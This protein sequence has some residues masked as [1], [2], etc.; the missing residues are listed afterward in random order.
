MARPGRKPKILTVRC[1]NVPSI[2]VGVDAI[3]RF[4]L[5]QDQKQPTL[6]LVHSPKSSRNR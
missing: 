5:A 3:A 2:P 6:R 1:T 4:L